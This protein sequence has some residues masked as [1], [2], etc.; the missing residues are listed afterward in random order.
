[1]LSKHAVAELKLEYGDLAVG[2]RARGLLCPT[3]L[4]G[5]S[6][7]R[8][9]TLSMDSNGLWY[10]CWRASC[11]EKGFIPLLSGWA[12]EYV[13]LKKRKP[14]T[15]DTEEL[16]TSQLMAFRERYELTIEE[17]SAN[18]VVQCPSRGSFIFPV[19]N[20][21]GFEMGKLERWYDWNAPPLEHRNKAD[22]Y[23][24]SES[25]ITYFP[26]TGCSYYEYEERWSSRATR[27][28]STLC[29]VE[30]ALSAIKMNRLMPTCALLGSELREGV[31]DELRKLPFDKFLIVLDPDAYKKAMGIQEKYGLYKPIEVKR[32]DKDPKDTPFEQ[33]RATFT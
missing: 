14:F 10:K 12:G 31:F 11:D 27:L 18:G 16:S 30:D 5:D 3:C 1:M 28:S 17:L 8:S 22:Y 32:L 15:H 2:A 6:R 7:E 9:F 19:H 4:G 13:P 25:E 21:H 26:R 33:L 20:F 24:E 29:I 23:T